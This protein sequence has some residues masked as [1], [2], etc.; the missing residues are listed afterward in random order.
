M[1]NARSLGIAVVVVTASAA[2]GQSCA[3]PPARAPW[4]AA[5]QEALA[6]KAGSWSN[7]SL[8]TALVASTPGMRVEPQLGW[9]LKADSVTP[10]SHTETLDYL[11]KLGA[12]RGSVW[13]SRSVVGVAG[14][15]SVFYLAQRDTALLRAAL[16]RMMEGGPD[17]GIK[18]DIAILED[19]SRL[20][21]GRKQLYGTQMQLANGRYSPLAIED[22]AHVDLRR[23][24]A[25]LPPLAWS[26]CNANASMMRK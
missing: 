14:V 13:P 17:E 4:L 6:E 25:N 12:T 23:E 2:R 1:I 16:K 18:T 26:V 10:L 15:R 7:D 9:Q 5:Q 24:G 19:Q 11:K 20:R 3:T 8:R 21:A 22:S